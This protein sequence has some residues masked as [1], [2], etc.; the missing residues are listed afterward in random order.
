MLSLSL[1]GAFESGWFRSN[2]ARS[3]KFDKEN[4]EVLA[5]SVGRGTPPKNTS[6]LHAPAGIGS[7]PL[8]ET[9]DRWRE[10]GSAPPDAIRGTAERRRHRQ[11]VLPRQDRAALR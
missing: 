2:L 3:G 9:G 4:Q 11:Q 7:H 1:T 10:A 5:K 6:R 8:A